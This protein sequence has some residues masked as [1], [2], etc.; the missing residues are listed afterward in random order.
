MAALASLEIYDFPLGSESF[1]RHRIGHFPV[2][3]SGRVSRVGNSEFLTGE[4]TG[5]NISLILR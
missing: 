4:K 1:G 3:K 2:W 5:E